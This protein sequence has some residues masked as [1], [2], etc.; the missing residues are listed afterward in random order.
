MVNK[1]VKAK[2]YAENPERAS[3]SEFAVTFQGDNDSHKVSYRDGE[4]SCSCDFFSSWQICCHTMAMERILDPM[5]KV[6]QSIPE[7]AAV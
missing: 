4:W 6:K 7:A 2:Q 1:I 5:I 3:F